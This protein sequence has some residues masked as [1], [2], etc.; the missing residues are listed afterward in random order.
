MRT[1]KLRVV[2]AVIISQS[3]L[4]HAKS[5]AGQE[6]ADDAEILIEAEDFDGLGQGWTVTDTGYCY[7]IPHEWSLRKI[8]AD[9]TE[10]YAEVK[11]MVRIPKTAAYN[12][13]VRYES[14]YGFGSLFEIKIEQAGQEIANEQFG[15]ISD[16]KYFPFSKGYTVQGPWY[17]HGADFACQK[18]AVDLKAG[19]AAITIYKSKNEVPGCDRVIDCLMLTTNLDF[20]ERGFYRGHVGSF[21]S[22]IHK[23]KAR[24][25]VRVKGADS[26]KSPVIYSIGHTAHGRKIDH[27]EDRYLCSEGW[28][29][30]R[31]PDQVRYFSPADHTPWIEI[32]FPTNTPVLSI[33]AYDGGTQLADVHGVSVDLAADP[34]GT[35]LLRRVE[36][37]HHGKYVD[38]VIPTGM[39]RDEALLR[40][41]ILT[42]EEINEKLL[43][44]IQAFQ[45]VGTRAR[46]F[47]FITHHP[48]GYLLP[49]IYDAIGFTGPYGGI[50]TACYLK[51]GQGWEPFLMAKMGDEPV[52]PALQELRTNPEL[53][54]GFRQ[55]L[56][57]QG[58]SPLSFLLL[59]D[60]KQMLAKREQGDPLPGDDDLWR[61]VRPTRT[62]EAYQNPQ[63]YYHTHLYR[64]SIFIDRW[65]SESDK[66]WK[67]QS[68]SD[69]NWET[70]P[71][72]V[73][74]QTKEFYEQGHRIH[75]NVNISPAFLDEGHLRDGV[76][77]MN[78]FKRGANKSARSE[79][80]YVGPRLVQTNSYLV[81]VLRAGTKY[82]DNLISMYLVSTPRWGIAPKTVRLNAYSE[83][84]QGAKVLVPYCGVPSFNH[85]EGCSYMES[86][87]ILQTLQ[88]LIYEIGDVEDYIMT[89]KVV[90]AR[91]ALGWSTT[92]DI[93]D[94]VEN[95]SAKR[96]LGRLKHPDNNVYAVERQSLY[97]GLLHNQAKVD[98]LSEEDVID[99]YLKDYQVYFLVADHLRP[100][101]ARAI[102]NWVAEGG[103]LVSL[104]GGGLLDHLNA[105]Q[106]ILKEV[107]G[108]NNQNLI[109]RE[110]DVRPKLTL[111][112]MAPI[113][114]I[115][116]EPDMRA[117]DLP[118][119]PVLAFKQEL[120]PDDRAEVW[121]RYENGDPAVLYNKHGKGQAITFG[122]LPGLAYVKSAIP[123]LPFGRGIDPDKDLSAR[124]VTDYEPGL[125]DIIDL[126]L[127]LAGI[128]KRVITSEPLVE[129]GLL[130]SEE[131]HIIPMAN[132]SLKAVTPL[133]VVLRDMGPIR[134]V[135]SQQHGELDFQ[136]TQ[137]GVEFKLPL[138]LT[139]FLV[140][141]KHGG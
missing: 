141:E 54:R 108:V 24:I 87:P 47:G 4:V 109:K 102:K 26:W 121:G 42:V 118:P 22:I 112:H 61:M 110:Y 107:L 134:S 75:G 58:F 10:D 131:S 91:V 71:G 3:L 57:R 78:M 119:L 14:A 36:Y 77:L 7:G 103:T 104:P 82:H 98:I 43:A 48:A 29:K 116:F 106:D 27:R 125:R 59:K 2:A 99:G 79:D 105:D 129:T 46:R 9:A 92:T 12:L 35:R 69:I 128:R 68:E 63:L 138:E 40:G 137:Q 65:R 41:E 136:Q 32:E 124:I 114:T 139:D 130:E 1:N 6:R 17:W 133:K 11:K 23:F 85:S 113:D 122:A 18:M 64:N 13:W 50:Q 44:E 25:Y 132:W 126:P 80:W 76:D 30:S 74:A 52:G 101:A 33:G 55:Y 5:Q 86:V 123:L 81:S 60:L 127:R 120:E 8:T 117:A 39:A 72:F 62:D 93:W 94:M 115:T 73:N 45:P 96:Q 49:E 88:S 140:I 28:S 56:K 135:R 53:V 97:L 37:A 38:L 100:E 90:P 83:I 31:T 67:N 84:A 19:D 111:L 20:V 34:L 70:E 51:N 95:D 89:S 16:R 15:G 66:F 21:E